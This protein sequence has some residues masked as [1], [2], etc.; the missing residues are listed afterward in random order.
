[1]NH[2][3]EQRTEYLSNLRILVNINKAK[4]LLSQCQFRFKF[5]SFQIPGFLLKQF[6]KCIYVSINQ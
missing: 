1:M 2:K 6:D 3:G 4:F 5:L